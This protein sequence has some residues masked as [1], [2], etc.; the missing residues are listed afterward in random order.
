MIKANSLTAGGGGGGAAYIGA[1]TYA[2]L[3]ALTSFPANTT[4]RCTDGSCG[5]EVV[6]NGTRWILANG[7][8]LLAS[9]NGVVVGLAP[10]FT[11]AGGTGTG[12]F[13]TAVNAAYSK[14]FWYVPANSLYG[15]HSAGFYYGEMSNTTAITFYNNTYSPTAGAQPT[16][17]TSKTAFGGV[18]VGGTGVTGQF[19]AQTVTI[20]GNLMGAFGT[21]KQDIYGEYNSAA[22]NKRFYTTFGGQTIVL[23]SAS[24][25]LSLYGSSIVKNVAT[26][27]QRSFNKLTSGSSS[28]A[29]V[30]TT[31]DTT[32][33]AAVTAD[34][35]KS[36]A[37]DYI[38][39]VSHALYVE[40]TV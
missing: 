4:A 7:H 28:S 37:T 23:E 22:S 26:N 16:E 5:F 30:V 19:V 8:T 29:V 15:T 13:G 17:P 12:T 6:F 39:L 33:D 18:L 40:A 14:G 36:A 27:R 2:Q 32:A 38:V 21:V 20:P 11:S 31:I 34:I 10:T 1:Y 24:T 25:S 3:S 9:N 35:H